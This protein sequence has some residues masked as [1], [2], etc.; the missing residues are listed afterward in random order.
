MK[1]T[2]LQ[3]FEMKVAASE[4]EHRRLRD[5][6]VVCDQ[7]SLC[8]IDRGLDRSD[9]HVWSPHVLAAVRLGAAALVGAGAA[10]LSRRRTK[11]SPPPAR[12]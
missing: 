1:R 10:L 3:R 7:Q 2:P 5:V 4:R 8:E 6:Q 11:D 9:V 12:R